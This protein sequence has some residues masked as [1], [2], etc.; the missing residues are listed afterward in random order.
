MDK[1]Y[2]C[3][4]CG[5]NGTDDDFDRHTISEGYDRGTDDYEIA[6]VELLCPGCNLT[7]EEGIVEAAYCEYCETWQPEESISRDAEDVRICTQCKVKQQE[8]TKRRS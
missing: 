1:H 2:I 4:E 8:L 5:F 6:E 3:T 7:E